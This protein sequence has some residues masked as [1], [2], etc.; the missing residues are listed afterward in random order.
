M[1]QTNTQKEKQRIGV[2]SEAWGIRNER[3]GCGEYL[4]GID[5]LI[6]IAFH[7]YIHICYIGVVVQ[8]KGSFD[9]KAKTC[10][11][12]TNDVQKIPFD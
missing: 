11:L 8:Q 2:W 4:V 5:L 12:Q 1:K 10:R 9:E 3:K 6:G 7:T